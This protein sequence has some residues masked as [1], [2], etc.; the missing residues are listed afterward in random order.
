MTAAEL[1]EHNRSVEKD[2]QAADAPDTRETEE[3]VR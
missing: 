1:L 2:G 3:V